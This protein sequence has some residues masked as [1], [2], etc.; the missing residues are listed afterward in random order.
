MYIY[1]V[2][3]KV[4]PDIEQEW[5]QWM[6]STHINEVIETG[7]FDDY[8]FCELIEPADDEAKTFVVQYLTDSESR[9]QQYIQTFAPL[10]RQ[11][12]YD[13]FSDKFIA[14]RTVMK[15]IV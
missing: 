9:Y 8:T 11:K 10:L 4:H 12:G 2:T 7:M 6:K 5:L 3:I 13:R 1:N 14:F 15:K